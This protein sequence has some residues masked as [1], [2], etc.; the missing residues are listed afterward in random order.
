M[1]T[2]YNFSKTITTEGW[3]LWQTNNAKLQNECLS[4]GHANTFIP[5]TLAGNSS[6]PATDGTVNEDVLKQ[7]LRLAIEAY[8]NIV[9]G[10]PCGDTVIQLYRGADRSSSYVF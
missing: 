5:S 7:N 4:L 1:K 3:Q 8:I 10:C 6:D 2:L 9:D